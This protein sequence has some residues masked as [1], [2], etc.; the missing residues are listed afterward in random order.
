MSS[1][2]GTSA[3][4]SSSNRYPEEIRRQAESVSGAYKAETVNM[5][6]PFENCESL[7]LRTAER[8][9]WYNNSGISERNGL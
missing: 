9:Y 6:G 2:S 1:K 3:G 4:S 8:V 5:L 7:N